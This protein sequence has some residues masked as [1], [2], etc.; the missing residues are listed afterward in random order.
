LLRRFVADPSAYGARSLTGEGFDHLTEEE[1]AARAGMT[2]ERVRELVVLGL[3]EPEDGGFL[4]RDVMRAR[5]VAEL[6]S[7]GLD[8]RALAS[9]HASG[10]LT[11]GYLESAARRHPRTDQT[12]AEFSEQ[13]G[14]SIDTLQTCYIAFG[15]PR[16]RATSFGS[17]KMNLNGR[18]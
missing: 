2:T 3:L 13:V 12:F 5:M 14:L 11:L 15:L 9:A 10:H 16:P 7:K 6:E 18:G 4:R 1:L 8:L 17:P